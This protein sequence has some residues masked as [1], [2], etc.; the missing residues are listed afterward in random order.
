MTFKRPAYEEVTLALG[1]NTVS[2]RPSL[3]AA[4]TL[5]ARY[6]LPT[7][8]RA[9]E[10]GDLTIILEIIR[11]SLHP[12]AAAHSFS[13]LGNGPLS[14]FFPAVR[15]PL[16]DLLT[17]FVPAPNRNAKPSTSTSTTDKP[18]PF[19]DLYAVLYERA[20]GWLGWTPE[21][22][23]S[24]TPTEIDRAYAAHIEK[25]KAIHGSA[26]DQATSEQDNAYTPERL[27][28][29]D[30]LGYDPAFDRDGLTV[31][32]GKIARRA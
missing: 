22:A 25:L 1:V 7:M 13:C 32:R 27:K 31:L 17:M 23:W 9:L 5:E 28:E 12:D 15:Q 10:E 16:A 30:E 6:G 29:I 19:A 20:T 3:R 14:H 18:M 4:A 2:L 21:V 24:A 8:F 11:T 26:D